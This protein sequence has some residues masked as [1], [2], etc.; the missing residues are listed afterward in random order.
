MLTTSLGSKLGHR[1]FIQVELCAFILNPNQVLNYDYDVMV[2]M[3]AVK[4]QSACNSF[5][6]VQQEQIITSAH[7]LQKII[8]CMYQLSAASC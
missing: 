8:L 4:G 2:P 7:L 3:T 1:P 6:I 5:V